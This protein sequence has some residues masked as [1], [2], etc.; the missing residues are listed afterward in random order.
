MF[1]GAFMIGMAPHKAIMLQSHILKVPQVALNLIISRLHIKE[2]R[3]RR[4]PHITGKNLHSPSDVMAE[5]SA[6]KCS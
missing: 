3:E 1:V 6:W 5:M 4:G 2:I